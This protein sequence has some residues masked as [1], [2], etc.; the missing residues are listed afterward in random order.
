MEGQ[1][2]FVT[3]EILKEIKTA[4]G[5]TLFDLSSSQSVMLIFLR[6]FGCVFC[7][8]ALT[9]LSAR[10]REFVDKGITLAFVH[11][12][13]EDV[14]KTYF[15]Q[16]NLSHYE[17]V[18]DPSCEVYQQFGLAKGSF[19]QL[20]GLQVMLRGFEATKVPGNS[21]TLQRIG[22]SLQM[23]GIFILRDGRIENSFVHKKASDRPNY[24]H[25]LSCC[26]V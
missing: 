3:P 11:M 17:S 6:H 9:D 16:F 14:A 7:K 20:F 15:D 10:E 24:D 12:A 8:E 2:E 5:A 26:V 21:F 23:P 19:N 4:S 18:S 25:L 1:K 22:D 13:E